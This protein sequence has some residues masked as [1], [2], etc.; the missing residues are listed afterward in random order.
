MH[1]LM[2]LS[3][4]ALAGLCRTCGYPWLESKRTQWTWAQRWQVTLL[5]FLWSPLLMLMTAIAILW[6]GPQGQMVW[7]WEGWWS[8]ALAGGAIG[9]AAL[10]N[11]KLIYEGWVSVQTI[12]TYPQ[13]LVQNTWAYSLDH[14]LPYAAQV[15]FWHSELVITHGLIHTLTL[16][17]LNAVLVHEQAHQHYR[18][19]FWF[20]WWGWVRRVTFWL[21]HST[22]LWQELLL[23]RELRADQWAAQQVDPLVL[24]ESLLLMVNPN[25]TDF[26]ETICAAMHT[27][28]RHRLTERI[29]ALL[30]PSASVV[31]SPR[32][33][34]SGL[35]LTTLPLA[36]IP[37]HY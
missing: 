9:I 33:T 35:L 3:A 34:W 26:S 10:L 13:R 14:V 8:Y 19:T 20:F 11:L 22:E 32:W 4:L 2:I 24:A 21:P 1:L 31:P 17:Q 18:D 27:S 15:G 37:F 6:M 29:D 28:T 7:K 12:H 23:L 36:A 16:E 25:P 30:S 5:V